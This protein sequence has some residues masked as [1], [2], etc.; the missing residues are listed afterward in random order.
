MHIIILTLKNNVLINLWNDYH[1]HPQIQDRHTYM[2]DHEHH[3]KVIAN[4]SK[5]TT[6][7]VVIKEL[8][9]VGPVRVK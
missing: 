3:S 7:T 2:W 1:L 4:T 8:A 6:G 9:T 5:N